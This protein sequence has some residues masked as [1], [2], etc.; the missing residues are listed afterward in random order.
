MAKCSLFYA[1]IQLLIQE[2][3]ELS[4]IICKKI[5]F[6]LDYLLLSSVSVFNDADTFCWLICLYASNCI[7][8]LNGVAV[9]VLNILY[10]CWVHAYHADG[11][12]LD[13]I[14]GHVGTALE[15]ELILAKL[16]WFACE[17]NLLLLILV[18]LE[19]ESAHGAACCLCTIRSD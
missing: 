10:A 5:L 19:G 18:N 17:C 12:L 6:L 11:I 15:D 3:W 9:S 16:L 7:Y 2:I 4:T 1:K 14:V 13:A 8:S